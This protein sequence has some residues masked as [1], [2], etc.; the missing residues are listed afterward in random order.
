MIQSI[1][2]PTAGQGQALPKNIHFPPVTVK[3]RC[4]GGELD[5][6]QVIAAEFSKP[7][8]V[9]SPAVKAK[10]SQKQGLCDAQTSTY[11]R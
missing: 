9:K 11:S 2:I 3:G 6:Y 5:Q 4:G 10:Y 8:G 1:Q 7:R